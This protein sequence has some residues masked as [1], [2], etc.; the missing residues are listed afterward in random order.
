MKVIQDSWFGGESKAVGGNSKDT[1][2][3]GSF[4]L[5]KCIKLHNLYI[6]ARGASSFLLACVTWE[7]I[8]HPLDKD[9]VPRICIRLAGFH[10]NKFVACIEDV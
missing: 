9:W 6:N 1:R 3:W 8:F 2:E 4:F 5:A 10:L 7:G